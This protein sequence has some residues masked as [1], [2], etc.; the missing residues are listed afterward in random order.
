MATGHFFVDFTAQLVT[1]MYPLLA[2]TLD[3]S[4]G[5]IGVAALVWATAS[6]VPQPL[7][8]YLGDRIGRRWLAGAG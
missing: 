5:L 6:S 3:L 1:M 8:G 7:F 2:V 4:L